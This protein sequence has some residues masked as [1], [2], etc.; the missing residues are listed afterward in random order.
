MKVSNETLIGWAKSRLDKTST[1]THEQEIALMLFLGYSVTR[2]SLYEDDTR[3][4]ERIDPSSLTELK[5][6][7]CAPTTQPVIGKKVVYTGFNGYD[8]QHENNGLLI[9]KEYIVSEIEV[10]SST[11]RVWLEGMGEKYTDYFNSVLFCTPEQYKEFLSETF[12]K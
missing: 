10:D 2:E 11:T 3:F 9:G 6:Y 4:A 1:L 7:G 8:Y 5:T 12:D